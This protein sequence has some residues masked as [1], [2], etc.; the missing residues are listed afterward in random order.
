[1]PTQ[2]KVW[3]IDGARIVAPDNAVFAESHK[4]NQLED[5]IEQNPE[6]LGESLLVIA[7]QLTIPNVGRLDLLCMDSSGKLVIVELKRDMVPRQ[8]VAQGLDYASWLNAASEDEIL[9]HANQYLREQTADSEHTLADAFKDEFEAELPE[10]VCQN[11]RILLVAAGLDDS[12]ERII[13]YLAQKQ[14][15][16]NAVFFNYFELSDKK[17]ILVRSVLVPDSVK[18][19]RPSVGSELTE[20]D[21]MSMANQKRTVELVNISRRVKE[22]WEERT[23]Y[24]GTAGGSFRYRVDGRIVYGINV[25]GELAN[26]TPP[27]GELDVWIS[28]DK[29]AQVSGVPEENIKQSLSKVSQPFAA[30]RM[31]FVIRLRSTKEAEA[32]V[33][34]LREINA[35]R[36]QKSRA[37]V[38]V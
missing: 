20:A 5:W 32:L 10:W 23:N 24:Y 18:P 26:P 31:K 29:L 8:A 27:A 3:E 35:G 30:G 25:S 28:T 21:L 11:H 33:G 16:I 2:I 22:F 38:G 15:G 19:S 12:A 36:V 34:L 9:G 13:N 17:Q 4:E 37:A 14:I 7:R 6:I 1:M